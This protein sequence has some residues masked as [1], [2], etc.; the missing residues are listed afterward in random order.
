MFNESVFGRANMISKTSEVR[1]SHDALRI[2]MHVN[3]DGAKCLGYDSG[4]SVMFINAG[5]VLDLDG[6]E[7]LIE[8]F[9]AARDELKQIEGDSTNAGN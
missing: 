9:T 1:V 5:D 8:L 7:R 4:G 6:V 3:R 2:A